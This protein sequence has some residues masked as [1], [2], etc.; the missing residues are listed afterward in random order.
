MGRASSGRSARSTSWSRSTRTSTRPRASPHVILPPTS[1]LERSHY[2]LR[3]NAFAVRNV[4][5]YS[6]PM[7]ERGAD[8][9]HDW[10]ICV[11]LLTRIG[12][13]SRS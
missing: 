9:R 6:P 2:D 7:F 4:A 3:F 1:P 10:E 13:R 5:K 11:E 8:Q 12:P